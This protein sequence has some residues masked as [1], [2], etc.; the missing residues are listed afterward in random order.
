M[1]R[2]IVF[3]KLSTMLIM[4]TTNIC[5][6]ENNFNKYIDL[7]E[8]FL[9]AL[10]FASIKAIIIVAVIRVALVYISNRNVSNKIID[11][12]KETVGILLFLYLVPRF[13]V[14]LSILLL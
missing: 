12:F 2:K 11:I 8:N 3:A 14:I 7:G 6:A 9:R 10:S 5:Y 1:K 4:L 13:P